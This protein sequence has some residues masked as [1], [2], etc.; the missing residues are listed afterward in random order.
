MWETELGRGR[1]KASAF[2]FGSLW[3]R[4]WEGRVLV[5]VGVVG[6]VRQVNPAPLSLLHSWKSAWR[7]SLMRGCLCPGP[8]LIVQI[9][10]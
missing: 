1:F 4:I 3:D 6:G 2:Q 10:A 5:G 9:S 8:S 7:K